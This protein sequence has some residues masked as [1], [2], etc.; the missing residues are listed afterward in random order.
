MKFTKETAYRALRTFL[1]AFI[2]ALAVGIVE[3][4]GSITRGAIIT[5][6][7]PAISAGIAAVMNLEKEDSDDD[8]QAVG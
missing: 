7:V 1:Q 6:I 4:D 3:A 5:L 8:I 2:P